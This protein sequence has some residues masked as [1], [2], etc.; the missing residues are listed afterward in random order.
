MR[1]QT[2][3]KTLIRKTGKVAKQ[4]YLEQISFRISSKA[5]KEGMNEK[6]AKNIASEIIYLSVRNYI[7]KTKGLLK[8]E[9]LEIAKILGIADNTYI[10]LI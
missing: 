3:A 1:T 8:N 6:E 9:N 7:R 5:M 2:I 10:A 4:N